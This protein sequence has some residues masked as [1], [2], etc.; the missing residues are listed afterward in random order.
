MAS[1]AKIISP[2]FITNGQARVH[3]IVSALTMIINIIMNFLLIGKYGI[4]GAAIAS[5]ILYFFYGGIYIILFKH[6][7][8]VHLKELILL[9][10]EEQNI[11]KNSFP[12]IFPR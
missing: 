9:S 5:T 1:I 12:K 8:R 2:Y 10:Q 11:L 4:D 3:L 7:E 6:K